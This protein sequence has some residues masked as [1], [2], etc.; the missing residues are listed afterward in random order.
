MRG[1]KAKRLRRA[2]EGATIG[3]PNVNYRMV[4]AFNSK[5]VAHTD[6]GRIVLDKCTR[7]LYQKMKRLS[8]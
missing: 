3:L 7:A 8:H 5:G 6:R 4:K 1:K 2:A